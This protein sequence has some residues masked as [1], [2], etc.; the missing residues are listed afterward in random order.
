MELIGQRENNM[1]KLLVLIMLAISSWPVHAEELWAWLRVENG[2]PNP[3][4][5]NGSATSISKSQD[6]LVLRL[7]EKNKKVDDFVVT[8]RISGDRADATFEPP[9]T[10]KIMLKVYGNYSKFPS[11]DGGEYKTITLANTKNGNFFTF[12]HFETKN[13]K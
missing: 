6:K 10:E 5:M 9:N 11:G 1:R 8:I 3:V 12:S 4:V 7:S 13:K 2:L